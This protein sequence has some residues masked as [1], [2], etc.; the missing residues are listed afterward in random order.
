MD[1]ASDFS[2]DLAHQQFTVPNTTL[3]SII[4][5]FH[6]EMRAGLV[7]GESTLRMLRSYVAK[8]S[9]KEEGSFLALDL[10]GTNFR[11]FMVT[12]KEGQIV[13]NRHKSF[14]VHQDAMKGV[15]SDL[16]DFLAS[17]VAQFVSEFGSL[18]ES[19][20]LGF[21]FSFPVQQLS[22]NRGTLIAW[23][24]GFDVEGVVGKDVVELLMESFTRKGLKVEVSALANDTVG[25]MVACSYGD[26][27]CNIGL[28]LGTG[29]NACYLEDFSSLP[30]EQRETPTIINMEWG[31]FDHKEVKVLPATEFDKLVD[32]H[33][34]HPGSQAFEKMI[35]G[36]YLGEISRL[37]LRK[38]IG[39]GH[40]FQGNSYH[41]LNTPYQF[42]TEFLSRIAA[43][44]S[45]NL[46]VVKTFLETVV[47]VPHGGS[48]ED[49]RI[50]SEVCH[51]VV[52]RAARLTV[53]GLV[54][55]LE[56]NQLVG[57]KCT[58]AVDGS[59]FEKY[60]GFPEEMHKTFVELIGEENTAKV[61]LKLS[62]DGSSVG[63][64][65]IAAVAGKSS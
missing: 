4:S 52:V 10:G 64:A 30:E 54:A 15:A 3:R 29:T 1:H 24:K 57:K 5:H 56:H 38:L 22:I 9:G 42:E 23:T 16:F 19:Y 2:V 53:A 20:K 32:L 28:I 49:R 21:T 50:V 14:V 25:T 34:V 45:E 11:V 55:I 33:S 48:I 7:G 18:E 41:I 39:T 8:A 44:K 37:V 60:P 43:D 27:D 59:V 26:T 13:E 47:L 65:I 61:S 17:S 58:I 35:S 62:K 6:A 12:I 40:L 31:A 46:D 63:A 51:A 36:M